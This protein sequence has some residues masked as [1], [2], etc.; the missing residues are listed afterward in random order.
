MQR[1]DVLSL[2]RAHAMRALDPHEATMVADMIRFAETH[3]DCLWRTC[4]PGHLTGSA[5]IVDS[6]RTRTL[7][8][9]HVKLEKWL[10]LGGHADGDPDLLAGAKH[11]KRVDCSV[12]A[13]FRRLYSTWTDTSFPRAERSRR[14]TTTTCVS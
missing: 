3:E 11:V 13:W 4:V 5:W 8:T 9:H 7:L 14:I 10:Q 2:L 1:D 12:C 6:T